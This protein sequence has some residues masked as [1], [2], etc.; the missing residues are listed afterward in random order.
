MGSLG[1]NFFV[2]IEFSNP[3]YNTHLHTCYNP[4]SFLVLDYVFSFI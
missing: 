3:G 2:T 4:V 1:S